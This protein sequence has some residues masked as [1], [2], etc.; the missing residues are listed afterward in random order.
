MYRVQ[1]TSIA[2]LNL[3][4]WAKKWYVNNSATYAHLNAQYGSAD[5]HTGDNPR[6]P[7]ATINQA[8]VRAQAG[9][10]IFVGMGHVE[11]VIT[12]GGL[13]VNKAGLRIIGDGEGDLRPIIRMAGIVGAEALF[14]SAAS[15][16]LFENMQIQCGLDAVTQ[17]ASFLGAGTRIRNCTFNSQTP[18]SF[19]PL[20]PVLVNAARCIVEGCNWYFPTAGCNQA[21]S[22][23]AAADEIVIENCKLFGHWATAAI[24][25]ITAAATDVLIRD[26]VIKSDNTTEKPGVLMQAATTGWIYNVKTELGVDAAVTAVTAA[27]C[28][29]LDNFVVND[30]GERGLVVGTASV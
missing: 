14:T 24:N 4:P 3:N 30:D 11:T 5:S 18:A 8:V 27:A 21:L 6:N 28:S 13:T 9:D 16:L 22:F 29:W 12:N 25:N 2:D 19:Q 20:N 23:A 26:I 7:L 10:I 17:M 15:S 1:P